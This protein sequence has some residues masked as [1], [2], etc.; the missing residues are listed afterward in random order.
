MLKFKGY[1]GLRFVGVVVS[2]L[3]LAIFSFLCFL[4]I[5]GFL[6]QEHLSL[7]EKVYYFVRHVL[8][9]PGLIPLVVLTYLLIFFKY[10]RSFLFAMFL[11]LPLL[12]FIHYVVVAFS[13][14]ADGS[15]YLLIQFFEI[16]VG[17]LL[18]VMS[19]K[20]LKPFEDRG[21]SKN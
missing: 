18:I 16:M 9:V 20:E 15:L 19:R 8:L 12:L 10:R 17:F 21:Q 11:F 6:R 4:A 14:H 7:I 5:V 13:A 1:Q 2:L 3:G